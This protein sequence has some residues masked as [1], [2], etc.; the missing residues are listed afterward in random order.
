MPDTQKKLKNESLQ[1]MVDG[2]FLI[3]SGSD[4]YSTAVNG[5]KYIAALR[6]EVLRLEKENKQLKEALWNA[7]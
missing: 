1:K 6:D 5:K 2:L 7:W 3:V 4:S